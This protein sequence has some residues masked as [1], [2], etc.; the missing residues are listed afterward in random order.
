MYRHS[1]TIDFSYRIPP[2]WT[3]DGSEVKR[4]NK[5]SEIDWAWLNLMYPP[6]EQTQ[7][8]QALSKCGIDFGQEHRGSI[9][10]SYSEG[11]W[12]KIRSKIVSVS[13]PKANLKTSKLW[14]V[15]W[16]LRR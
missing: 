2:E 13:N 1:L 7:F 11:E 9:L 15:G 16:V 6:Q 8:E 3:E 5:P 10:R 12:E 14:I 4:N